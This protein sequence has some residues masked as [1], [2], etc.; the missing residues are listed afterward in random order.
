MIRTIRA[1]FGVAALLLAAAVVAG[2]IPADAI[3]GPHK[4]EQEARYV[5]NG[6]LPP[7]LSLIAK[8]RGIEAGTPFYRVPDTMM[9]D[10]LGG[11]QEAGADYIYAYLTSYKEPPAGTKLG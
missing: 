6:A 7:D 4:N 2:R 5:L 8:A 11:Y 10:I 3:P 9:R 1:T